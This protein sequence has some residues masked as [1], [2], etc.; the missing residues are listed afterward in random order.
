[1]VPNDFKP[2]LA[3]ESN[4]VTKQPVERF[5]S[6]KL[7]GIRC[8]IFGGVPYTRSLKTIPNRFIQAYVAENAKRLEGVDCEI[9]V[10][11]RNAPD[12]FNKSTSGCMSFEGEPD[13][14]LW[15]FD[16]YHPTAKW[17]DRYSALKAMDLPDRVS[18]LKHHLVKSQE[19]IDEFEAACLDKGCEGIML[20]D[21]AGLYKHG[22]SGK[23]LPA[24]QKVKRFV[25]AEF[26]IIGWEPKYHNANEAMMNELGR[27]ERSTAKEGMIALDTMGALTL[28]LNDGT[29]FSCGSGF[30][31]EMRVWL[32]QHRE[33]LNGRW[34]KVKYFDNGPSGYN[35]PRF[36]IFLGL[37]DER[38]M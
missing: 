12:V 4:K 34:A 18:I 13:F 37:R 16:K 17:S 20:R 38:D 24:L 14:T 15:A 26:Q 5:V 23:I 8:I 31:D 19:Q 29:V 22:R 28:T 6:E 35:V 27:T 30:T 1:M 36:P 11:E 32:W 25:D 2:L 7:D 21:G 33:G 9:I 10:G 3:I